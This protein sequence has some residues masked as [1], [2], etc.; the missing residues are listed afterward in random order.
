MHLRRRHFDSDRAGQ[1]SGRNAGTP[2]SVG[3][4]TVEPHSSPFQ[5]GVAD[6]VVQFAASSTVGTSHERLMQRASAVLGPP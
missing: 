3:D 5:E 4:V 6:A 2:V 1:G